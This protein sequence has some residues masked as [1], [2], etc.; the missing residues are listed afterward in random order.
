M[1]S[2]APLANLAPAGPA[3]GPGSRITFA[4]RILAP[5]CDDRGNFDGF[6]LETERGTEHCFETRDPEI[7]AVIQRAWHERRF[8]SVLV[9][10]DHLRR[11]VSVVLDDAPPISDS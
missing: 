4:G 8:V 9:E 7:A 2:F 1:D 10:P 3:A 11:P 5:L 6:V